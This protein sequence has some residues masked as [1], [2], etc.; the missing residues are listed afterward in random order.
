M[1][2]GVPPGPQWL[3]G[4]GSC[5][6]SAS[7]AVSQPQGRADEPPRC[8]R[9]MRGGAPPYALQPGWHKWW[10]NLSRHLFVPLFFVSVEAD[11][12]TREQHI[13][14]ASNWHFLPLFF[15]YFIIFFPNPARRTCVGVVACPAGWDFCGS[16]MG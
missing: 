4:N 5:S 7:E 15:Y 13:Y 11:C 12:F 2:S 10:G 14:F 8:F 3:S 9:T 6:A 1:G 16:L